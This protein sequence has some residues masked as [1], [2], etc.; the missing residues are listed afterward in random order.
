MV[1]VL[2][3]GN[4]ELGQ[5]MDINGTLVPMNR[6]PIAGMGIFGGMAAFL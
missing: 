3:S 6:I 2:Q 5:Q 1:Q 4:A